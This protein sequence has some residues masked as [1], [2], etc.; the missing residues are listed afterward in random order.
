MS[1]EE[2]QYK[3]DRTYQKYYN[4]NKLKKLNKPELLSAPFILKIYEEY[5]N[6]P[7]KIMFVGKE[8]NSWQSKLDKIIKKEDFLE[9]LKN[10]YQK[11]FDT[12]EGW[13]TAFFRTY[14]NIREQL[15]NNKKG[16]IVWNNLLKF[17]YDN[18]GT[19]SKNAICHSEEL[20]KISIEVF[21]EE[22]TVL[23]PDFIF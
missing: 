2:I 6:S 5:L 1:L 8:V 13:N 9:I 4:I 3:L 17:S 23:K 10:R 12:E 16:T 19:Y 22:V 11:E 15:T 14:K 18:K 7:V 21:K 20:E